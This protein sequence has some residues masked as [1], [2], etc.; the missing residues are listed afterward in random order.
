LTDI[1]GQNVENFVEYE[2]TETVPLPKEI[3]TV[4]Y[5]NKTYDIYEEA[6]KPGDESYLV[7]KNLADETEEIIFQ[8]NLG[9]DIERVFVDKEKQR[10]YYTLCSWREDYG[11]T[12]LLSYDLAAMQNISKTL[13][14]GSSE[15]GEGFIM[16]ML[17]D[18]THGRIIFE[19]HYN[20][21]EQEYDFDGRDYLS[22]DVEAEKIEK[23]SQNTYEE[24]FANLNTRNNPSAIYEGPNFTKMLFDVYLYDGPFDLHNAYYKP[25]YAGAYVNDGK[26][27][28]RVSKNQIAIGS[29][30]FWLE[31]GKYVISGS[32]IYDTSGKMF[33]RKITDGE[34]LAIY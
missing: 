13:I 3:S 11:N 14:F 32:Y 26:N 34:I 29:C 5:L 30:T 17:F 24:A 1:F 7:V 12:Y 19:A 21:D 15:Y 23:I 20:L 8:G 22:F 9:H 18:E 2:R 31:D 27:N 6:G 33:E 25:K 4:V 10:F 16:G 28:I